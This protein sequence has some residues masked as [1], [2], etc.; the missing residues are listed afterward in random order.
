MMAGAIPAALL[1][2]VVQWTF[3]LRGRIVSPRRSGSA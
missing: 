3:D 2:L 1:A